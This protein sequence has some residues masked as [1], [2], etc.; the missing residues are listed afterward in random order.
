MFAK[1]FPNATPYNNKPESDQTGRYN[2]LAW[3]V[4]N[5]RLNIWPDE[6]NSWPIGLPRVETVA[7]IVAFLKILGFDEC[8]DDGLEPRFEKVAI[9]AR[10]GIPQ[11]VARQKR[12]GLWTSKLGTLADSWHTTFNVFACAAQLEN[13]YGM[14]VKIMRRRWDG[15]APALPAMHPPA[16]TIITL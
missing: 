3:A 13:S 1:L 9:Y 10:Q 4:H 2:C 11:H 5:D 6:D 12:D 8:S 14:V 16:P 7:S 15:K